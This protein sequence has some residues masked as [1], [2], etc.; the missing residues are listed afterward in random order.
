MK[1][2]IDILRTRPYLQHCIWSPTLNISANQI[3]AMEVLLRAVIPFIIPT[4]LFPW[5]LLTLK[6]TLAEVDGQ[7]LK[8]QL[9]AITVIGWSY[10]A[11][12]VPYAITFLVHYYQLWKE[13]VSF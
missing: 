3:I 11:L 4:L 13:V 1:I 2:E 12:N 5:P 7:K 9:S 10:I 8:S 6:K